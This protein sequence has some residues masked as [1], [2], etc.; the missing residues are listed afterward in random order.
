M[1]GT[2]LPPE[3]PAKKPVPTRQIVLGR[4]AWAA[5][6]ALLFFLPLVIWLIFTVVD[7]NQ[8]NNT[9]KQLNIKL[10]DQSTQNSPL[11]TLLNTPNIQTYKMNPTDPTP[12]VEV[13]LHSGGPRLW[14][15]TY[16]QTNSLAG[17]DRVF[18]LY[19]V[20]NVPTPGPEDYVSLVVFPGN[21]SGYGIID[22]MPADLNSKNYSRLILTDEPAEQEV[23]GKPTGLIRFT[24]DVSKITVNV[25]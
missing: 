24:L 12:G 11:V 10:Q 21:N 22:N 14:A 2:T 7:L 23:K 25:R 15:V 5:L 1:E 6:L 3:L 18:V 8:Q 4:G 19:A 16:R 9:L 20:K 13:N 17:R